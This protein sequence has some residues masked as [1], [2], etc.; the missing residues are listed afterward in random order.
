MET[1]DHSKPFT[2]KVLEPKEKWFGGLKY[3]TVFAKQYRYPEP[4][5]AEAS[6]LREAGY[7]VWTF[8]PEPELWSDDRTPYEDQSFTYEDTLPPKKEFD[9]TPMHADGFDHDGE[10]IPF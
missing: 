10:A 7:L 5:L 9:S 8:E 1:T 3:V 2:L 4:M 6:I